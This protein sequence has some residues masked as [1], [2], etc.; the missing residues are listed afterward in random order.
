MKRFAAALALLVL[1]SVPLAVTA[2]ASGA[3]GVAGPVIIPLKTPNA[4]GTA[5]GCSSAPRPMVAA[6]LKAPDSFYIN[7]HTTDF[8]GGAIRGQLAGTSE[9]A[10]GWVASIKLVGSTEP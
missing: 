10:F 7:I 4:A 1:V 6:I 5:S 8:P 9:S 2:H 3:A